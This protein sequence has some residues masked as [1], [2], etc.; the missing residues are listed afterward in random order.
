MEPE[1][2]CSVCDGNRAFVFA[3]G[4]GGQVFLRKGLICKSLGSCLLYMPIR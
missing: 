2:L 4:G 3:D 1:G